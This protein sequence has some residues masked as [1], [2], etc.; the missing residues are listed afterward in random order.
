MGVGFADTL[1]VQDS[2][3]ASIPE[4]DLSP[5][6]QSFII[7]YSQTGAINKAAK[8][9]GINKFYHY[10]WIKDDSAYQIAFN[11]AQTSLADELAEMA[12]DRAKGY[13]YEVIGKDGEIVKLKRHSDVLLMFSLKGLP[14]GA[15]YKES[16]KGDTINIQVK[17]SD[18]VSFDFGSF[19][20]LLK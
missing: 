11:L 10:H 8:L 9:S 15:S 19:R 13:D 7:A 4:I 17:D 18:R 20:S 6:Q 16:S 5:Q 14:G 1:K 3:P 12:R 2:L